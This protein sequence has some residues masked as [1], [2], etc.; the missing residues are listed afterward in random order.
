MANFTYIILAL[1]A[2]KN[3]N[4]CITGYKGLPESYIRQRCIPELGS[5]LTNS[6]TKKNAIRG[7]VYQTAWQLRAFNDK[8]QKGSVYL[9][10]VGVYL[11][12]KGNFADQFNNFISRKIKKYFR[13]LLSFSFYLFNNVYNYY[14]RWR[15]WLHET[16]WKYWILKPIRTYWMLANICRTYSSC[17]ACLCLQS[18]FWV[19]RILWLFKMTE[20]HDQRICI[21]FC[22]QLGKISSET[23]QIMQKAFGNECMSKTRIKEWYNRFKAGR[24]SVDS[25]SRLA[26]LRRQKHWIILSGYDLRLKVIVD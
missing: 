1:F 19:R 20:K 4:T 22:F 23:I 7:V 25:D 15:T 16:F 14:F 18:Y 17:A 3:R 12:I 5:K 10:V 21:K 26:D 8:L 6:L 2:R 9:T 13:I 11:I 24:T